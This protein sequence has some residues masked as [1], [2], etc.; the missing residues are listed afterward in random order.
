MVEVFGVLDGR[1]VNL[2][3]RILLKNSFRFVANKNAFQ[4]YLL[5]GHFVFKNRLF[6][7]KKRP[8]FSNQPWS[9]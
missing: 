2:V 8:Y 4:M 6:F 5:K 7:I 3:P 9:N 1:R